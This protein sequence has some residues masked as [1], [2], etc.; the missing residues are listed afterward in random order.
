LQDDGGRDVG[1]L[2]G[3]VIEIVGGGDAEDSEQ[4]KLHEIAGGDAEGV[5]SATNEQDRKKD[6]E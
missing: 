4:E 2:N 5:G 1:A 3:E 6:G